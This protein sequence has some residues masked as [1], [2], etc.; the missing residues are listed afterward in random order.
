M[1]S[2]SRPLVVLAGPTAVGKTALALALCEAFQGEVVSADSRQLYR[3]MDIAT[4]KATPAERARVP[5]HL[6]D[7]LD[8]EA[9][10]S[11]AEYQEAAY[12]AIDAIHARGRV[13]FLVGGTGLYVQAVV[14]G[15]QIPQ[16]PPNPARRAGLMQ[17]TPEALYA[18]LQAL[19]PN[20]ASRILPGNVRRV[21]RALEVIEATGRLMSELQ[22]RRPPPYRILQ[23]G[24]TLPRAELY[25]RVDARIDGMVAAGLVDEV[26]RLL[27]RGYAADLP[28]MSGLGYGEIGLYVRGR[29]SLEE[30]VRLLKSN[31]RKF[32]R[33]QYNWF[34]LNDP[35][36]HWFDLSAPD[37]E[38]AI[39]R[40]VGEFLEDPVRERFHSNG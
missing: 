12:A 39:K 10:F 7:V 29:V 23:I 3:G 30:A 14:E 21:V 18:R 28:S 5:H 8:P 33:H 37:A 36:V 38:A 22:Q 20:A 11:L 27:A 31:T 1:P 24:L 9:A 26:Q 34:R 15:L 4:A 19:D 25:R 6:V 16:V 32:I 2:N 35:R 40:R 17:E 13:P